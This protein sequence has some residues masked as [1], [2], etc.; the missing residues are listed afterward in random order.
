[1]LRLEK[2]LEL[3]LQWNDDESRARA[4]LYERALR[5]T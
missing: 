1:M 4:A 5:H 3:K 2:L